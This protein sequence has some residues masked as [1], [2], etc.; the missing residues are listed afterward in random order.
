MIK[1]GLISFVKLLNLKKKGK[2][3]YVNISF[4]LKNL[5]KKSKKI[6]LGRLRIVSMRAKN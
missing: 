5:V 2:E 1:L 3:K 4:I 6:K